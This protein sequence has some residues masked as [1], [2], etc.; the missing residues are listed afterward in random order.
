MQFLVIR[1]LLFNR[2]YT[3]SLAILDTLTILPFEGARNGR[4]AYRRARILTAL[5]KMK[6]REYKDALPLIVRARL[7]P[8]RPGAGEPYGAD[9]RIEDYLEAGIL[10]KTGQTNRG[11]ELLR[12]I[13]EYTSVH[14][15]AGNTH[16][17]ENPGAR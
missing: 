7:W 11:N 13:S 10:R 3:S 12:K 4:D 2:E 14:R 8:D 6:N 15:N 5:Q 16:E 17:P 1:T 9:T